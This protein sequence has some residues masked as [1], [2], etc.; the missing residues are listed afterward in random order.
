VGC[1][2]TGV[3]KI[4]ARIGAHNRVHGDVEK[5]RTKALSQQANRCGVDGRAAVQRYS[6][7]APAHNGR[8]VL[9]LGAVQQAG[10][11]R[12]IERDRVKPMI[13]EPFNLARQGHVI[14]REVP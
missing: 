10:L 1:D 8:D 2:T 14:L 3:D 12:R 4:S 9:Q 11:L 7:V 6:Q 5:A 13:S